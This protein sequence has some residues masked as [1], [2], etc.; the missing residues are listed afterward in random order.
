MN[1]LHLH[2]LSDRELVRE[3]QHFANLQRSGT[4]TRE[5]ILALCDRIMEPELGANGRTPRIVEH[6]IL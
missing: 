1:A 4:P 6:D 3:A 2:T 5:V